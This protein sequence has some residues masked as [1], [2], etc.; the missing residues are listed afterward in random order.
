MKNLKHILLGWLL[1]AMGNYAC[2]ADAT[3]LGSSYGLLN[4]E[5]YAATVTHMFAAKDG[6]LIATADFPASGSYL[7][8]STDRGE[9]WKQVNSENLVAHS[10]LVASDGLILIGSYYMGIA[11]STD[12]GATWSVFKEGLDKD[13]P[14][15]FAEDVNGV[16]YAYS[17]LY[18]GTQ[19]ATRILRS[20]DRGK[21]W[22]ETD[23]LPVEPRLVGDP[24]TTVNGE[25]Y[26]NLSGLMKSSDQGKTWQVVDSTVGP[27]STFSTLS[28]TKAPD[29]TLYLPTSTYSQTSDWVYGLQR[30]TDNGKTWTTIGEQLPEKTIKLLTVLADG[31]LYGIAGSNCDNDRCDHVYRSTDR[32]TTWNKVSASGVRKKQI[33]SLLVTA[34]GTVYI[35]LY[36]GGVQRLESAANVNNVSDA[37]RVFN[38]AEAIHPETFPR[39]PLSQSLSGYTVR[40][41]PASG[42]YLGAR[43]DRLYV[44]DGK[45]LNLLDVGALG[46]FAAKAKA[47]G[48]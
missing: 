14:T 4:V 20:I 9:T 39:G 23:R 13:S 34:D 43:N 19:P 28:A 47:A 36:Q 33:S 17:T 44:H 41:Y 10:Y 22:S 40:F 48:Y 18:P 8:R 37:D 38:W 1:L 30:S 7:F 46:D 21:S 24:I 45:L 11:R 35:G 6:S 27:L 29:G 32:G 42:M 31:T 15:F 12:N 26:A 25:L 3:W 2:A 16:L 5:S